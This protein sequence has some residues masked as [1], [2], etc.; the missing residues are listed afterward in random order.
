MEQRRPLGGLE[1]GTDEIEL[2]VDAVER[3]VADQ[4]DEQQI[5]ARHLLPDGGD[6]LADVVGGG[7]VPGVSVSE[8]TVTWAGSNF[9]V[10]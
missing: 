7:G 2:G 6:R 9:S 1:V 10:R 3:P 5:L 8:R 4:E